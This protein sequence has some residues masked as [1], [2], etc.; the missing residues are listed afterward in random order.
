[1]NRCKRIP[2][3][4]FTINEGNTI[5]CEDCGDDDKEFNLL[6][7]KM[8]EQSHIV[9]PN[10]YELSNMNTNYSL[11]LCDWKGTIHEYNEHEYICPYKIIECKYCHQGCIQYIYDAHV[12]VCTGYLIDCTQKCGKLIKR[13]NMVEHMA[14]E[15]DMTIIKC[16]HN[17]C[18]IEMIRKE[19]KIHLKDECLLRTVKCKYKKQGCNIEMLYKDVSKHEREY[20]MTHLFMR[21]EYNERILNKELKKLKDNEK[22]LKKDVQVLQSK[23]DTP[24]VRINKFDYINNEIIIDISSHYIGN[25]IILYY[26]K[27]IK[28]FKYSEL[29][30]HKMEWKKQNY[31][32]NQNEFIQT[33]K[34]TDIDLDK[35]YYIKCQILSDKH[36]NSNFSDIKII[37][38]QFAWSNSIVYNY[39]INNFNG[40]TRGYYKPYSYNT[41]SNI[42][43]NICDDSNEIIIFVGSINIDEPNNIIIGAFGI[44]SMLHHYTNLSTTAYIPDM[45][46]NTKYKVYWYHYDDYSFGFSKNDKVTSSFSEHFSKYNTGLIKDEQFYKVI[47]WKKVNK[48]ILLNYAQNAE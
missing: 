9:C 10:V 38:N 28:L 40:W 6:M 11:S 23:I 31:M 43:R 47:Y 3:K 37:R 39:N 22:K 32:F 14:N 17:G 36:G 15:C 48:Q 21:M 34:L 45:F 30:D 25:E 26:S 12:K 42:L 44:A 4:V 18:N 46:E 2:R 41:T 27:N 24:I 5:I 8:L 7:T 35:N 20:K 13:G 33:I 29:D 19:L 16:P 1:M